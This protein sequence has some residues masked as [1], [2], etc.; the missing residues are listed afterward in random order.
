MVQGGIGRGTGCYRA[1][2]APRG[3]RVFALAAVAVSLIAACSA[4]NGGGAGGSESALPSAEDWDAV[5]DAANEEGELIVFSSY[6]G[7]EAWEQS[8]NEA[9]PDIRLKVERVGTGDLISRVDQASAAGEAIADV[10]YHSNSGWFDERGAENLVAAFPE[11]LP[12]A[13]AWP[14]EAIHDYHLEQL[15]VP[16]GLMWNT[17][18][19]EPITDMHQFFEVADPNASLGVTQPDTA[20]V[21]ANAMQTTLESFDDGEFWDLLNAT[22]AQNMNGVV[23]AQAVA[24]GELTYNFPASAGIPQNLAAQGAPVEW[25]RMPEMAGYSYATGIVS[26][27]PNPNAALVFMDW[28]MR[29]STIEEMLQT[30]AQDCTSYLDVP[31]ATFAADDIEITDFSEWPRERWDEFLDDYQEALRR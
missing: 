24:A 26:D 14:A 27:P 9:Y 16:Y 10:V 8:F 5:V 4:P 22:R 19:S 11:D 2:R 13:E 25:A 29:E 3:L 1:S 15:V 20:A 12:A 7:T 28:L 23:A 6:A 21:A 31:S 17:D 18:Q 30:F